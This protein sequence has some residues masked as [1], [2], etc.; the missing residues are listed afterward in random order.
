MGSTE[1]TQ[2]S[3]CE[4]LKQEVTHLKWR[5]LVAACFLTF[6]SYYIYDFPASIG[7]GKDNTIQS[8]FK[9][10]GK[11]FT[12]SMNQALYSVYSYPN[13]IVAVFGGLLI[14]KFLGLR[15]SMLLF[16]ALVI[17]GSALFYVSM[18]LFNYPLM[19]FARV[20]FGLGADS[21]GV[22][23]SAFIA[24]WFREGRG[25]A[26]AF[27]ITISFS[28][29]GSSFNFLFSPR[30]AEQ[31]N[32]ETACLVGVFACAVSTIACIIMVLSDVYAERKGILKPQIGGAKKDGEA[33]EEKAEEEVMKI[34]DILRLPAELWL[35]ALICVFCYCSIFPFV[36]ISK[37][38]FQVKYDISSA[39]A[40]SYIS[41][42]Q[43]AS[44]AA[45]PVIG[46]V[47]DQTGRYTLWLILASTCFIGIHVMF[48]L[49][50][51]PPYVLTVVMGLFYSFLVSGLWPSIPFAVPAN[52][53]ALAYA[54]LGALQNAGLATFPLIAGA[55]LDAH[56]PES[57][58]THAP[59]ATTM[60]PNA[61]TMEP[62][63]GTNFFF[64]GLRDGDEDDDGP[65]ADIDGYKL[66]LVVFIGAAA[67]SLLAS[68]LLLIV[69]R[70]REGGGV[71]SASPTRRKEIL[72]ARKAER[73]GLLDSTPASPT[74]EDDEVVKGDGAG[75]T[76]YS[77]VG[78]DSKGINASETA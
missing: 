42:Y 29:V 23:Q 19:V 20:I 14:D 18:L 55:I 2:L 68:V 54:L 50:A 27:G 66:C 1:E 53:C 13:M 4:I 32:V 38:F 3:T 74:A 58:P 59:N 64:S 45:S 37:N 56:T 16:I 61:T 39:D 41:F 49:T 34:R 44:A 24:R 30:I 25:M 9:A 72:D 28:R 52:M 21:L 11:E 36:G 75:Y 73:Q 17:L 10:E 22:A 35:I 63:N 31:V 12:E 57:T 67:V 46:F 7:T 69:D 70:S 26:L 43:F 6:G 71:L 51:I 33:A 8:R 62:V 40:S 76:S 5:V 15:K 77:P 65:L 60:V 78:D 47:V 48:I